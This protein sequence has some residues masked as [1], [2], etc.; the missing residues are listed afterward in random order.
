[1]DANAPSSQQ[2]HATSAEGQRHHYDVEKELAARLRSAD[3]AAR[4]ELYRSVYD[5]L[6]RRVPHH[7]QLAHKVSPTERRRAV[8][9]QLR[10]L[11]PFLRGAKT[12]LEIGP[13]D[14]ELSFAVAE[15]VA[16]VIGV[17]VSPEIAV[18]SDAPRN[19]ELHLSDGCTIP[20]EAGSVD[21]AFSDQV[22]EHLHP[23]DALEQ[24]RNVYVTL[25]PGG[26]YICSTPNRL[27]GPHDISRYFEHETAVGLHLKEYTMTELA[28]LLRQVGFAS[29]RAYRTLRGRAFPLSAAWVAVIERAFARLPTRLRRSAAQSPARVLLSSM[30]V[31]RK[32]R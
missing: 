16:R 21:V 25:A 29:T 31:A 27:L 18:R 17:D 5:E 6:F 26:V 10:W 32:A 8:E 19:F 14:C 15:R 4:R 3:G 1:V 9:R 23:D 30:I 22:M 20:V 24:L 13:G 7:P 28:A 2:E 12:F 11:A